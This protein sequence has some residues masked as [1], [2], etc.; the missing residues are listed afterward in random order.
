MIT[1]IVSDSRHSRAAVLPFADVV[2]LHMD[3]ADMGEAGASPVADDQHGR[4]YVLKCKNM[5]LLSIL[6]IMRSMQCNVCSQYQQ[7]L[8]RIL[9]LDDIWRDVSRWEDT[10]D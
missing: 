8:V 6:H 9:A 4:T 7:A 3:M 5:T 1:L 2:G 10:F